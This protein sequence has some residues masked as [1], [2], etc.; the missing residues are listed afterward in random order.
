MWDK[1]VCVMRGCV[2]R[3]VVW[4]ERLCGTRGCV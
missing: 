3:E 1:R 2:G 4:D